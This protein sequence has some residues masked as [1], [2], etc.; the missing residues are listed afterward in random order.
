MANISFISHYQK[1]ICNQPKSTINKQAKSS[2]KTTNAM[3]RKLSVT[4]F[5]LMAF[6]Q[7]SFSQ[8]KEISGKV[9]SSQDNG[10]LPGVTVLVKG[11]TTGTITSIDGT[12]KLKVPADAKTLVFSTIGMATKEVEIGSSTTIDVVM[13]P[14]AKELTG[15][16]VTAM[17]ISREKKS[18]GY[19]TQEIS[20]DKP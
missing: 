13:S 7:W 17:G 4:L 20:G 5:F 1:S 10:T 3:K 9:T 18:L 14:E 12:Y 11:T 16:V 8:E 19:A 15:V 6:L 2:P